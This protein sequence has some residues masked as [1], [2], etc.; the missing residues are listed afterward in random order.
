MKTMSISRCVVSI[1][2]DTTRK[3][4]Y[5]LGLHLHLT[6]WFVISTNSKFPYLLIDSL[7]QKQVFCLD[8]FFPRMMIENFLLRRFITVIFS[9]RSNLDSKDPRWKF[10]PPVVTK[11]DDYNAISVL[12]PFHRDVALA[13]DQGRI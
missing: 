12:L 5:V 3:L 9:F 1:T 13:P 6:K 2:L 10:C 7:H 11:Y 4:C 8:N